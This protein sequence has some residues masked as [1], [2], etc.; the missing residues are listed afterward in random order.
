MIKIE[1]CVCYK[2][3]LNPLGTTWRILQ[4]INSPVADYV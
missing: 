4:T 3:Y 2:T 1:L